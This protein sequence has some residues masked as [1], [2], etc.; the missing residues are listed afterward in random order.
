MAEKEFSITGRVINQTG[1]GIKGLRIEA[2][3]ADLIFDD[4]LAF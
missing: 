3:D 1:R 2:W 4:F